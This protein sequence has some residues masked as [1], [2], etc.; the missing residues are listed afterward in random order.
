M[1]RVVILTG[2]ELRHQYFRKKISND[3]RFKV[4]GSFCEGNERSLRNRTYENLKSSD[5]EKQH[6]EA[7]GQAENDF[8]AE[9]VEYLPDHS[10]PEKIDKGAINDQEFVDRIIN[11][12]PDLI[13]CYGSSL[14]RSELLE[15]FSGK[16]L[17]VHLGLSPYYR[18][19]GTNVWPLV[20]K[21]LAMVGATFMYIDS[22]VDTGKIIHQITP[23]IFLGDSAHSIGNRLIRDMTS[24][25]AEIVARFDYLTSERQPDA[26]GLLYKMADFDSDSCERLYENFRAGMIERYLEDSKKNPLPYLVHNKGLQK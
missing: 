3:H 23:N 16:F 21:Q 13:V 12:N 22:G 18:G 6:V 14:I 4:V 9:I 26:D 5:L 15:I 17:N 24:C 20:N 1:K 19:S 8:F 2:D 10:F 25:Y 7:R 11:L